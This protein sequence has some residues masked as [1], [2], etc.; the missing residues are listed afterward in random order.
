[1]KL[2]IIGATGHTNYVFG[3]LRAPDVRR[4]IKIP[5]INWGFFIS[6]YYTF[7]PRNWMRY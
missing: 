2:A 5:V 4:H 3:G 7:P 1:M 6:K